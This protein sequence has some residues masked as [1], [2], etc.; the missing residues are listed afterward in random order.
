MAKSPNDSY[1]G[2]SDNYHYLSEIFDQYIGIKYYDYIRGQFKILT[3]KLSLGARHLDVGCGTGNL[4]EYSYDLGF[5]VKGIDVSPSMIRV[6]SAKL[7]SNIDLSCKSL[8]DLT[9]KNW[10]IITANN[11]VLNYLAIDYSLVYIFDIISNLLSQNGIFYGDIVS[12]KDILQNWEDST[13]TYSDSK[14]F[15]CKVTYKIQDQIEPRGLVERDWKLRVNN[16]WIRKN[17]E[18]EVLRGISVDEIISAAKDNNLSVNLS[19][20]PNGNIQIILK[21]YKV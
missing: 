21:K 6:A 8:F 3:E 2:L 20:F 18:I 11:D 1:I 12:D 14:T 17:P 16:K 15:Q 7:N 4:L 5:N 9:N 19:E 10:D 13:H